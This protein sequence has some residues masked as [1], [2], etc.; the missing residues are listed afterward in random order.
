MKARKLTLAEFTSAVITVSEA[1]Y[2]GNVIVHPDSHD[3]TGGNSAVRLAV[4]DSHGSGSRTSASYR[5]GPY[6]CW[7][8]H[9]D[10]YREVFRRFPDA[11]FTGGRYWKVTYDAA[12]FENVFPETRYKNIGSEVF[13]VI[14]PELCECFDSEI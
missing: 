3:T 14:M 4:T 8:A 13:H 9:R 10:V 2:S 6:A 5:H 11:V 1:R 12:T 7:H